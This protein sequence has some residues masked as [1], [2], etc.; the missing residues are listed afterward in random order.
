MIIGTITFGRLKAPMPNGIGVGED[1]RVERVASACISGLTPT[2][3]SNRIS[4][5]R[6]MVE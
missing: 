6:T 3:S 4:A 2:R 5:I 1:R